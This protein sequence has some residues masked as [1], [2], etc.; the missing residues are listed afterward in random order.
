MPCF[1]CLNERNAYLKQFSVVLEDN[2]N[3]HCIVVL[4][5]LHACRNSGHFSQCDGNFVMPEFLVKFV[6]KGL[7]DPTL[8]LAVNLELCHSFLRRFLLQGNCIAD[9]LH[10]TSVRT[11]F[12]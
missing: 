7:I 11:L 4:Y 6:D 8:A 12:T 5:S 2:N 3:I 9:M 10:C 1:Y